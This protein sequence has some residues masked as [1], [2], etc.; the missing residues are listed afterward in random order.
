MKITPVLIILV[1]FAANANISAQKTGD[2]PLKSIEEAVRGSEQ[3]KGF[4]NYYWNRN[5]G[6]IF[7]E[8]DA[9]EQESFATSVIWGFA[10]LAENKGGRVLIDLTVP[11]GEPI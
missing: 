3:S 10:I 7:L 8:V 2:A 4:F 6:R 11:L 5:S 1:L 9:M